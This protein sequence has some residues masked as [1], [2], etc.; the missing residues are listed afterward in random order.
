[1]TGN[2]AGTSRE[3]LVLFKSFPFLRGV[4]QLMLGSLMNPII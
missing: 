2:T 1:M 3:E 4:A